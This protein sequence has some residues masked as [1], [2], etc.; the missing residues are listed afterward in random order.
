MARIY[1]FSRLINASVKMADAT[2]PRM[3]LTKRRIPIPEKI[4]FAGENA[5]VTNIGLQTS[6]KIGD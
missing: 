5:Y 1:I 6:R 4:T 3:Q 2:R